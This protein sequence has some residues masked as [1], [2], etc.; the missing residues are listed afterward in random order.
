[1]EF[2][3]ID[4]L[5]WVLKQTKLLNYS[6]GKN[7]SDHEELTVVTLPSKGRQPHW[8]YNFPSLIRPFVPQLFARL[9]P[10][11][12][13]HIHRHTLAT[14]KDVRTYYK[15]SNC[16]KHTCSVCR[17]I[18]KQKIVH[19]DCTGFHGFRS[20]EVSSLRER[21]VCLEN[22]KTEEEWTHDSW[23]Q[24]YFSITRRIYFEMFITEYTYVRD[25]VKS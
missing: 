18:S 9:R 21:I 2:K 16:R 14:C 23:S 1:M 10:D 17:K 15:E 24:T 20:K 11:T 25:I 19:G 13:A 5:K 7:Y 3:L 4:C 12:L 22:K 8:V 6:I